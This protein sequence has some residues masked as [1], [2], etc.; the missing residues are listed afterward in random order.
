MGNA[1]RTQQ[2]RKYLWRETK[3]TFQVNDLLSDTMDP[4][5]CLQLCTAQSQT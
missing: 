5:G 4:A 1:E 3:L 2:V